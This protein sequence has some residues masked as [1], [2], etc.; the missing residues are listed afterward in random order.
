MKKADLAQVR[1]LGEGVPEEMIWF[2]GVWKR[3]TGGE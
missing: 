1:K 2:I 3:V